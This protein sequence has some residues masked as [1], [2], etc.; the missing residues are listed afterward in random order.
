MNSNFLSLPVEIGL[1]ILKSLSYP[2]V[3][4]ILAI[5]PGVYLKYR[6]FLMELGEPQQ[7]YLVTFFLTEQDPGKTEWRYIYVSNIVVDIVGVFT[8]KELA[9]EAALKY[10]STILGYYEDDK[11][12]GEIVDALNREG[13]RITPLPVNGGIT[14]MG[15]SFLGEI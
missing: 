13:F 11:L 8:S 6:D 10:R 1:P 4:R 12:E 2:E 5:Y 15:Y 14:S 3:I 7:M 9:I